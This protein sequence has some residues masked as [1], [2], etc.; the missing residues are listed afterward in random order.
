MSHGSTPMEPKWGVLNK[1]TNKLFSL[2]QSL[3]S[4]SIMTHRE[5]YTN[6]SVLFLSNVALTCDDQCQ[7]CG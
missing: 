2:V 5:V 3:Q 4:A 7:V 6:E 1:K